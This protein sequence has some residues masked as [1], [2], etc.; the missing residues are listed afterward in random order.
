MVKERVRE[1]EVRRWKEGMRDKGTLENYRRVK[2]VLEFEEYLV[3]ARG[4]IPGVV[5]MTKLRGGTNA[6]RVSQGRYTNLE[7][8]ERLCLVFDSG[9]VE[10]AF[11]FVMECP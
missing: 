8:H 3:C 9:K 10:D 7:R 2:D 4:R 11:H 6:L 1:G 5:L